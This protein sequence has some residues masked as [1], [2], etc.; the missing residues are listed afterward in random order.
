MSSSLPAWHRVSSC[1]R[2]F[3]H[4]RPGHLQ[5]IRSENVSDECRRNVGSPIQLRDTVSAWKSRRH[6]FFTRF[7]ST[8]GANAEYVYI[9]V[10]K[11]NIALINHKKYIAHNKSFPQEKKNEIKFYT[12]HKYTTNVWDLL[13]APIIRLLYNFFLSIYTKIHSQQK[14]LA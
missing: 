3:V 11:L 7:H 12:P 2:R 6:A 14:Q 13:K 4:D 8:G 1:R 10:I 9:L 5:N